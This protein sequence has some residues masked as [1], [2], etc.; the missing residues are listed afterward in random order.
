[1][2]DRKGRGVVLGE[3]YYYKELLNFAE[4][5]PTK[6]PPEEVQS[7]AGDSR[8]VE[9]MNALRAANLEDNDVPL[10]TI[11]TNRGFSKVETYLLIS[12]MVRQKKGRGRPEK[13][14]ILKLQ[15]RALHDTK[16]QLRAMGIRSRIHE[17]AIKVL[18]EAHNVSCEA[19]LSDW[20]L[21]LAPF[22]RDKLEN[23]IR[24]SG[25]RR[26]NSRAK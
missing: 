15:A 11:L 8:L 21:R 12:I 25:V 23:H 2:S 22:D 24:R 4:N 16:K 18:E 14:S 17:R 10:F 26:T 6:V 7:A 3:G 13:D 9:L 1:M 20:G 5:F 19:A